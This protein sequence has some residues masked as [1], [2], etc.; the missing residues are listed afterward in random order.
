MPVRDEEIATTVGNLERL[1]RAAQLRALDTGDPALAAALALTWGYIAEDAEVGLPESGAVVFPG[2]RVWV[3]LRNTGP[4]P[5]WVFV[6]GVGGAGDIVLL[7]NADPSGLLLAPGEEWVVG[8]RAEL[9]R[10]SGLPANWPRVPVESGPRPESLVVIVTAERQDL[11]MLTQEGVRTRGQE[12]PLQAMLGQIGDGRACAT[13]RDPAPSQDRYA[14]RHMEYLIIPTARPQPDRCPFVLDERPDLSLALL[15]PRGAT[16][17][18][19]RVAVWLAHF[20]VRRDGPL[21]PDGIRL[22][23]LVVTCGPGGAPLSRAT[24]WRFPPVCDDGGAFFGA[25]DL[26]LAR[27]PVRHYLDVAVWLSSGRAAAA[28]LESLLDDPVRPSVAG[29]AALAAAAGS[30][31]AVGTVVEHADRAL[32]AAVGGALG[33]YRASFLAREAFGLGVHP[34]GGVP[35]AAGHEPEMAFRLRIDEG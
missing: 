28:D 3:R 19:G 5:F 6:I 21:D 31:N 18:P 15:A 30:L 34:V 35:R 2:D 12:T 33:V 13:A 32:A 10:T 23:A 16:P 4:T 1:A 20:A 9:G 29:P 27:G 7:T 22:D 26:L 24:T 11:S 14:I 17:A 25:R 8:R